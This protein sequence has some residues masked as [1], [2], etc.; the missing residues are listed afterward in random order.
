MNKSILIGNI[1]A[2]LSVT[3]TQGGLTIGK[4]SIAVNS[5]KQGEAP[6]YI[7][8]TFFGK[9]AENAANILGKGSKVLIEGHLKLEQWKDQNQQNRSKHSI[10][11]ETFEAL[12]P[13][14][15]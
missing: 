12:D 1:T 10:E 14:P 9:T 2:P 13:R 11:I 6:M 3:T 4:T 5:R 7:D 15:A 8:L